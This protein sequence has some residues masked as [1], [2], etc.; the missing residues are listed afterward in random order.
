M[1]SRTQ[2]SLIQ[3]PQLPQL[4]PVAVLPQFCDCVMISITDAHYSQ[5]LLFLVGCSSVFHNS[6]ISIYLEVEGAVGARGP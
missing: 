1:L 6:K 5:S 2:W 4:C 3:L